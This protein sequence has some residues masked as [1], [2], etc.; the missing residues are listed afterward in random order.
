MRR[1]QVLARL[2]IV[3]DEGRREEL[4]ARLAVGAE[5]VTSTDGGDGAGS[6]PVVET[7]HRVGARGG[8]EQVAIEPMFGL[9]VVSVL[10]ESCQVT[11]R[12]KEKRQNDFIFFVFLITLFW[13]NYL[14]RDHF[15]QM[16]LK[17]V[18]SKDWI[19]VPSGQLKNL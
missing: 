2:L 15:R 13:G 9:E 11:D 17:R 14:E 12:C 1:V 7:D 16:F 10:C 4:G 3:N 5:Q 8:A 18:N 19:M 6:R